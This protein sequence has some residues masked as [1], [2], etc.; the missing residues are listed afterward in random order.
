MD[1]Q[2]DV[3]GAVATAPRAQLVESGG[4]PVIRVWQC[5]ELQEVL[6]TLTALG[7]QQL[8]YCFHFYDDDDVTWRFTARRGG[9]RGHAGLEAR[10]AARRQLGQLLEDAIREA[11]AQLVT[12]DR[13][14]RYECEA[15]FNRE[16]GTWQLSGRGT[17]YDVVPEFS[18]IE[19]ALD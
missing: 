12:L 6:S 3:D 11:T 19:I 5:D 17:I 13:E 10:K 1:V 16:M 15:T 7:V 8:G 2:V 14:M 4:G 9:G 18:G